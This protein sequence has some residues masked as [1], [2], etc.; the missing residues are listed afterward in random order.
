MFHDDDT[1]PPDEVAPA[2]R[3]ERAAI[4]RGADRLLL[5]LLAGSLAMVFAAGV[6]WGNARADVT[7]KLDRSEYEAARRA[8]QQALADFR[9]QYRQDRATDSLQQRYR[10]AAIARIEA[11]TNKLLCRAQLGGCP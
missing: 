5:S 2:A 8:D 3:G 6:G 1:G 9:A 4:R 10:D 11:N 7:G